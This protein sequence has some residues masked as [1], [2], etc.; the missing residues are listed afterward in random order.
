LSACVWRRYD[1]QQPQCTSQLHTQL[2]Q[3]TQKK[4]V[5]GRG[6]GCRPPIHQNL[7]SPWPAD[8]VM[9]HRHAAYKDHLDTRQD[10]FARLEP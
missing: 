9:Q 3:P 2:K 1:A 10:G 8:W 4:K 5:G 6:G 7:D